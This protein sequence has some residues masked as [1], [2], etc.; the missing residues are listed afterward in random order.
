MKKL[1]GLFLAL[2]FILVACGG[3]ATK[4][5]AG[6]A[7]VAAE[8]VAGKLVGT[9]E[10]TAVGSVLPQYKMGLPTYIVFNA[11]GTYEYMLTL[12]GVALVRRGTYTINTSV[13]PWQIDF[14]QKE[15]K[16][17]DGEF[18]SEIAGKS[19]ANTEAGIF[20]FSAD[21]NLRAIWYSSKF[22]PRPDEM[23]EDDAQIFVK[24]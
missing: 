1:L 23:D 3:E 4:P 5:E 12:A 9:W 16:D 20:D 22:F 11:D 21:G 6:G 13:T 10:G 24:K 8:E 15:I 18:K 17:K 7:T 2:T 19:A 14:A